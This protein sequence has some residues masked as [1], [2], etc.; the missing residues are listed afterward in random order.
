VW[1]SA[2]REQTRELSLLG[3]ALYSQEFLPNRA[4]HP[5]SD[6]TLDDI[7]LDIV[8]RT[9]KLTARKYGHP[10]HI[11]TGVTVDDVRDFDRRR[12]APER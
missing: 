2:P 1:G 7:L 12:P 10:T 8:E 6:Q 5:N 9:F 11:E 3:R 4:D